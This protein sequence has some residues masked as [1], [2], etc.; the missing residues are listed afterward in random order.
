MC[1]WQHACHREVAK[2]S[3][4]PFI[5]KCKKHRDN[6]RSIDFRNNT[7]TLTAH[8]TGEGRPGAKAKKAR[9]YTE[10]KEMVKTR[11]L[12]TRGP[13]ARLILYFLHLLTSYHVTSLLTLHLRLVTP[14]SNP[15]V[16]GATSYLPCL[17]AVPRLILGGSHLRL[18]LGL[19]SGL[20]RVGVRARV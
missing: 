18:G 3:T 7:A 13:P 17:E 20:L 14:S 8:V 2:I 19:G 16:S 12:N 5:I 15:S 1:L 11:I 10:R 4:E 9:V 6:A